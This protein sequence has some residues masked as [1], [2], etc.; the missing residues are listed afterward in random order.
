MSSSAKR[1]LTI[2]RMCAAGYKAVYR[3]TK[4]LIFDSGQGAM[5]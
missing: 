1:I 5:V 2:R 3:K 4:D